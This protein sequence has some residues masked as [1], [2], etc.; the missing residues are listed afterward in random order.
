[1]NKKFFLFGLIILVAYA[2]D[3]EL[4]FESKKAQMA[5]LTQEYDEARQ[6]L[7]SYKASFLALQKQKFE[8]LD[9]KEKDINAS[10]NKIKELKAKNED[11]LNK[12]KQYLEAINKKTTGKLTA[13]YAQMKPKIVASILE[14]MDE[15]DATKLLLS[16]KPRA[17]AAIMSKMQPKTAS[18]LS[19][20]LK[21]MDINKSK[22]K[23]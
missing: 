11:I 1:M 10:L 7:Q 4:F 22:E 14:V 2:Q 20:M 18:K 9:K 15:D 8:L 13:I 12:T 5:V 6:N 3:C 16:L 19:L 17:V 23:K 21:N